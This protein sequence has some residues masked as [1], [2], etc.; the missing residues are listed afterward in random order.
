MSEIFYGDSNPSHVPAMHA[1]QNPDQVAQ[2]ARIELRAEALR[3]AAKILK[4]GGQSPTVE[5]AIELATWLL[6]EAA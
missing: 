3:I 5:S 6:G 2:L 1:V 4:D